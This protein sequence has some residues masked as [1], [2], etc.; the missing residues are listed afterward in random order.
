MKSRLILN[1]KSA[2][3]PQ[4]RDAVQKLREQGRPLEVRVTWEDGDALRFTREACADGIE[5]VVAGGGDGTVNEV[6]N[7]LMTCD[8]NSRTALGILPLGTANDFAT[9]CEIPGTPYEALE[10]ATGEAPVPVDVARV[11][12]KFFISVL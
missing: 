11:N 3:N 7:G 6:V 10:L 4:V 12:D 9:G 2:A 1:G 8:E 5:R